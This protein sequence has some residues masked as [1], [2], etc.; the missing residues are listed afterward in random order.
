M[1]P[2]LGRVPQPAPGD[3]SASPAAR[4]WGGGGGS[5]RPR[6]GSGLGFGSG[7]HGPGSKGECQDQQCAEEECD[8]EECG[9]ENRAPRD[10]NYTCGIDRRPLLPVLL[11]LSTLTGA[12]HMM[13]LEFPLIRDLLDGAYYIRGTFLVLYAITLGCMAYCA[14]C[15]PGQLKREDQRIAQAKMRQNAPETP[16]RTHKSWLYSAP[17]RRYDHYCRWLTNCIGLLNHREFIVM[18]TGLVILGIAGSLLDT[19]LVLV[20]SRKGGDF[21]TAFLLVM[22]LVYDIMVLT[23]AYPILRLH[24]GFIS[25]NELANE[26]KRNDFYVVVN[27]EDKL[28]A[29]NELSDDEF[30]ER[31]DAFQYDSS[32][33]EFDQGAVANCWSF[34]CTARWTP[35]QM[36]EF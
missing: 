8:P 18:V 20:I 9:D 25:R 17:I 12:L 30:N 19:A 7:S 21:L 27:R 34:W 23:L 10:D 31:F 24:I 6:G 33:N 32:R 22:H 14:L 13:L 35:G 16:K 36:G 26:W 11:V 15:D 2:I 5:T 4:Q 1:L 28:V 3:A 29:V